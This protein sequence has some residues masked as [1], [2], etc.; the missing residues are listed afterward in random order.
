M[1]PKIDDT[2]TVQLTGKVTKIE[3]CREELRFTVDCGGY[4]FAVAK[5]S[6]IQQ[7]E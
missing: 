2:V 6:Q 1:K 7:N 5:E 3:K 4:N